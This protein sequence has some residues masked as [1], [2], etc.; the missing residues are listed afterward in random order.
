MQRLGRKA[1]ALSW[2]EQLRGAHSRLVQ[3]RLRQLVGGSSRRQRQGRKVV[4]LSWAEQL[5][6]G[7]Q[8]HPQLYA[9]AGQRLSCQMCLSS[10]ARWLMQ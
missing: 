8:A 2:A 10:P 1:V 4:A 5:G 9:A 7:K 6:L 3:L